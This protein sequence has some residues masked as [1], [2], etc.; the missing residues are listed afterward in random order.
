M[1]V[2]FMFLRKNA[3]RGG[4]EGSEG[5][6][7]VYVYAGNPYCRGGQYNVAPQLEMSFSTLFKFYGTKAK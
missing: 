6:I 3:Y 1:Y 5:I 7:Y 2:W 4:G